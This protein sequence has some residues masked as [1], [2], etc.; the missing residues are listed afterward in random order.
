VVA[1]TAICVLSPFVMACLNVK[2][3]PLSLDENI[4]PPPSPKVELFVEATQIFPSDPISISLGH[5]LLFDGERGS[6]NKDQ[7]SHH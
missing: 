3:A 2:V 1:E 6:V 5:I 7:D 4:L